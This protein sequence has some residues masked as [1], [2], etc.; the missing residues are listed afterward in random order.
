MLG[1]FTFLSGEI[2]SRAARAA[3]GVGLRASAKAL[4]T[5]P[6]PTVTRAARLAATPCVR[7]GT[8]V[9]RGR[10]S[11]TPAVMGG[12]RRRPEPSAKRERRTD[13][14]IRIAPDRVKRFRWPVS[15]PAL[16]SSITLSFENRRK[17]PARTRMRGVVGAGGEKPPATRLAL[18]REILL[19]KIGGR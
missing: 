5:P 15:K 6:D 12:T 17:R 8:E 16:K 4:D 13:L 10:S 9:S 7:E 3:R 19:L 2:S 18:L 11:Q 1:K 14:G